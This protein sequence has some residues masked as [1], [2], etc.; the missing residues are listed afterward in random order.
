MTNTCCL[1]E[2]HFK[3]NDIGRLKVQRWKIYTIHSYQPKKKNQKWLTLIV[4]KTEFIVKKK[5]LETKRGQ[6]T[7]KTMILF[8]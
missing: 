2:I 3:F 1:K 5:L 6:S 8:C 4:D 7:V